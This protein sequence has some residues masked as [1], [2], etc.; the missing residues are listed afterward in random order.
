MMPDSWKMNIIRENKLYHTQ[1]M[2]CFVGKP[3]IN[4]TFYLYIAR[5]ATGTVSGVT[6]TPRHESRLPRRGLIKAGR[7]RHGSR[8]GSLRTIGSVDFD[9]V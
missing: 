6:V 2:E 3:T 9:V 4:V 7:L 1:Q 5:N 8:F